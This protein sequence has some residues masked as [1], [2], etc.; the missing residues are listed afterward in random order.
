MGIEQKK[1]QERIHR[2]Q[3]FNGRY[4]AEEY[5]RKNAFPP[6]AICVCGSKAIAIRVRSFH[7]LANLLKN[8]PGLAMQIAAKHEGRIPVVEMR[9]PGGVPVKYVRIGDAFAC[10]LCKKDLQ[11][12]ASKHPSDVIM[13]FDTGPEPDRPIVQVPKI[14]LTDE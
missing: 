10:D 4:T 5:Y 8:M 9:G 14:I 6:D 13:H 2:R 12:A 7:P 11:K 3:L 1:K